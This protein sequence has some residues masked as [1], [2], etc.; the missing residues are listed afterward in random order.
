MTRLGVVSSVSVASTYLS[1]SVS[2][3]VAYKN[4]R[5]S[6]DASRRS[7]RTTSESKILLRPQ[8]HAITLLQKPKKTS[9]SS[10]QHQDVTEPSQ[11]SW[12]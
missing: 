11:D 3:V 2:L 12:K 9:A 7:W 10:Q 1:G 4:S 6:G 8:N 5:S